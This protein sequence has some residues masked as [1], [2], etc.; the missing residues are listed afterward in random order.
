MP[1]PLVKPQA[2]NAQQGG[3]DLRWPSQPLLKAHTGPGSNGGTYSWTV[4]GVTPAGR[5]SVYPH[6]LSVALCTH[7]ILHTITAAPGRDYP[8]TMEE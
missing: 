3:A 7:T 6:V 5:G 8:H 4:Q 2:G 1:V